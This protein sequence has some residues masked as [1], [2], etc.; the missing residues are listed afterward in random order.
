MFSGCSNVPADWEI[1]EKLFI[2]IQPNSEKA[3]ELGNQNRTQPHN[4]NRRTNKE[5]SGTNGLNIQSD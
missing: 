2:I 5:L 1:T 3:G 4:T